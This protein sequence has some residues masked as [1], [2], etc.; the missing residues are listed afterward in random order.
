L[1]FQYTDS[2]SNGSEISNS[3]PHI[4]IG[5]AGNIREGNIAD[6]KDEDGKAEISNRLNRNQFI[7][8]KLQELDFLF[9]S[10]DDKQN[11]GHL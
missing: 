10:E 3:P 9:D 2:G 8:N 6:R 7:P 11:V 4:L 5:E 1:S